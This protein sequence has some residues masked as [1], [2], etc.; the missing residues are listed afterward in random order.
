MLLSTTLPCVEAYQLAGLNWLL[1]CHASGYNCIL[2][3]DMGLGKTIQSCAFLAY[4]NTSEHSRPH[5]VVYSSSV[6]QNWEDEIETW[7][8]AL[9]WGLI[10][11]KWKPAGACRHVLPRRIFLSY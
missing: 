9:L 6:L 7:A 8:P 10:A 2:A 1:C 4:L 11:C 3:D 5:L